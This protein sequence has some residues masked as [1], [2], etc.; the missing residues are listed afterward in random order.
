MQQYKSYYKINLGL[1]ILEL[2]KS[3]KHNIESI[4]IKMFDVYDLVEINNS[5]FNQVNYY[6]DKNKEIDIS[7]CL[8]LKSIEYLS[9]MFSIS[10]KYNIK[11]IKNIPKASG[12]GSGSANAA[13]VIQHILKDNNI[14]IK[15]LNM[16]DIAHHLGSDIPFFLSSYNQA[17]VKGIGH[18]IENLNLDLSY[19]NLDII[20][21]NYEIQTSKIFENYKNIKNQVK[22]NNYQ[23]ILQ[24]IKLKQE[25]KLINNLE[26]SF[27]ENDKDKSEFLILKELNDVVVLNG[28]GPSKVIINFKN[29]TRTRYAPSPTGFFHIGGARTAIFNYLFAKK[30]NGKFILRIEDTDIERNQEGGVESQF[31]NLKW[32]GIEIDE[33]IFN[34]GNFG[35]YIQ[36]KKINKYKSISEELIKQNKAYY[37]F[38]SKEELEIQRQRQLENHQTPKYQRTCL[39]LTKEEI[40]NKLK[41]N[42][43]YVIRLK[44]K[45]NYNYSW[46]DL[47]RGEISVPSSALTDPIIIKANG[48]AMYN[49]AVVIDD[50]DMKISHVLRGEE[51]IS[52]TPYQLAIA[53]AVYKKNNYIQYGHL[54][55]ITDE[56]GKKLSKRN[57]ELKQ[58]IE[59]YR[60][61]GFIPSA[62]FN[63]LCLLGWSPKT[64]NEILS[65]KEIISNFDISSLSKSS[66]F[67][68]EKKL[69]WISN[70]YFKNQSNEE[71]LLFVYPFINEF[72]K[73]NFNN[74]IND[75]LLLFKQQISS[76]SELNLLIENYFFNFNNDLNL[77]ELEIIKNAKNLILE[78]KNQILNLNE[79]NEKNIIN[80][81]NIIKDKFNKKGKELFMPIRISST[82]KSHGPDLAKT[83]FLIGKKQVLD[84][85]NNSLKLI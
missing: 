59:D 73:T 35:P 14:E 11:I 43:P 20:F 19:F 44:I 12:L 77:D 2:D 58:F 66:A 79:Y 60:N 47:I 13:I 83:I 64:K 4:F 1:N 70:Q 82:N 63:F 68:D 46:I 30:N 15:Q 74:L 9:N 38:C 48:V 75:V 69:I 67:F 78:F 40:L 53:E 37:C 16:Y 71:Y 8:V 27:N 22:L 84:N 5:N 18:I 42:I 39:K 10:K 61:L 56:S 7:N 55:I 33:S 49:F 3:N 6:N 80:I 25:F 29:E 41:N 34:E 21:P 85:L 50:I 52:N 62:L 76:A 28:S 45:D 24:N 36:S 26:K 51:H 23:D 54:S 17:F 81:I 32:L 65:K 57:K 72:Y 31:Y